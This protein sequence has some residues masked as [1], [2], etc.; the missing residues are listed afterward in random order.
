MGKYAKGMGGLRA[1]LRAVLLWLI[2]ALCLLSMSA[3]VLSKAEAGSASLGYVSSAISFISAATAGFSIS[4]GAGDKQ[5][6]QGLIAAVVF[7]TLLLTIGFLVRGK[8]MD[9]SGILSV[10]TFTVT[11][12][13][14]GSVITRNGRRTRGKKSQ[15]S[16]RMRKFS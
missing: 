10:V 9:P 3:L 5:F 15:R 12:V 14:F 13:L 11:G 6:L 7:V 2:T 1:L 8:N 4:R 16:G